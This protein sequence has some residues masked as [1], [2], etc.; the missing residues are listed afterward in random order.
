MCAM[1]GAPGL[2]CTVLHPTGVYA[3]HSPR[4]NSYR[5]L[6]AH[7]Y[8]PIQLSKRSVNNIVYADDVA[9]A[10]LQCLNRPRDRPAEEYII[11]GEAKLFVEWFSELSQTVNSQAWVRL[12]AFTRYVCR[13]AVRRF[14]NVFGVGCPLPFAEKKG[15]VFEQ[16]TVYCSDKAREHF[17]FSPQT[18]FREVCER[19]KVGG[20]T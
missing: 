20:R 15:S 17:G 18:S 8:V 1:V 2:L 4:I 10:L 3:E 11:N 5:S 12:P 7:N 6:L 19:L 14:L 16:E 13:G 9:T